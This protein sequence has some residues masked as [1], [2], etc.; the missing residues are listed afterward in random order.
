MEKNEEEKFEIKFPEHLRVI[1]LIHFGISSSKALHVVV[2]AFD[3]NTESKDYFFELYKLEKKEDKE[4]KKFFFEPKASLHKVFCKN[5]MCMNEKEAALEELG[6]KQKKPEPK[7]DEPLISEKCD[8]E[9]LNSK[10][11]I[12]DL[13]PPGNKTFKIF[14]SSSRRK[15]GLLTMK[16]E[17]FIKFCY[18]EKSQNKFVYGNKHQIEN[19]FD[20]LSLTTEKKEIGHPAKITLVY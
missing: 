18:Y 16:P 6:V 4:T 19:Y 11:V 8:F 20:V 15:V 1:E 5:T 14:T 10:Y 13:T 3:K 7:K 2:M 9:K 17:R 12:E